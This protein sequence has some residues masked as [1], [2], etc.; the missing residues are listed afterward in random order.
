[1]VKRDRFEPKYMFS[2]FS[3]SDG[4][5]H[6]S[7]LERGRTVG[8]V[9]YIESTLKLLVESIKTVRPK[10]GSKNLKFHRDN[11]R[12]DVEK[13]VL[14]FINNQEMIIMGHPPYSPDLAPFDFWLNSFYIHFLLYSTPTSRIAWWSSIA[15]KLY[16]H[17]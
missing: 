10:C 1:M 7:Y 15:L 9:T 12:P 14:S 13:T 17:Q 6:V 3:K 5:M 16:T 2:F 11:A 4:P 8:N